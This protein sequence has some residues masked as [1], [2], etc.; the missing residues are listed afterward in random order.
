MNLNSCMIKNILTVLLLLFI[1]IQFIDFKKKV[2]LKL[3]ANAVE[4]H[5]K[6]PSDVRFILKTSCNNCHF[7]KTFYPSYSKIQLL[8]LCLNDHAIS[9]RRYECN[10]EEA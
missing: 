6:I 7:S 1:S 9:W 3:S 10:S 2:S 5:Y 4:N 8:K